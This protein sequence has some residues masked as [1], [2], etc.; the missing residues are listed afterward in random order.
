MAENVLCSTDGKVLQP[1][2]WKCVIDKFLKMSY[3]LVDRNIPSQQCGKGIY[4]CVL[5]QCPEM[6]LIRQCGKDTFTGV[7][8]KHCGLDKYIKCVIVQ[9]AEISSR[10][11][12]KDT[13]TSVIKKHCGLDTKCV[14][15][16]CA[17]M[18]LHGYVVKTHFIEAVQRKSLV[19]CP[20]VQFWESLWVL[21]IVVP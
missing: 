8:K 5:A 15:A 19:P 3:S 11:C 6:C 2:V 18:C 14:I 10:L 12:G 20:T 17:E 13:F 21:K 16:R 1:G 9:C 7:T 4:K